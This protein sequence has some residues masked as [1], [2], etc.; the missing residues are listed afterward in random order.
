MQTQDLVITSPDYFGRY[1]V[2]QAVRRHGVAHLLFHPAHI[3]KPG[4][5][6]AL[7]GTVDYGREK[8]MVWWTCQQVN[9]WERARR[10]VVYADIRYR[11]EEAE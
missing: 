4:V 6:D 9:D 11:P 1:W 5:A 3:R 7:K 2:D 10:G 8:G